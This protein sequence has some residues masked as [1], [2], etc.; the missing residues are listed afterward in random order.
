[1]FKI[2]LMSAIAL[3]GSALANLAPHDK[4]GALSN[5][6]ASM[7]DQL[8]ALE[9]AVVQAGEHVVENGL[10]TVLGPEA[11]VVEDAAL[12]VLKSIVAAAT[13]RIASIESPVAAA[14]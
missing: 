1:M 11:A 13:A 7:S 10:T 6:N 5:P 2:N 9:P 12:P 4:S 14:A 8:K 3:V